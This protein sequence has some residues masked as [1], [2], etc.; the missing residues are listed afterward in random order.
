MGGDVN[1]L[2]QSFPL[3]P[4]GDAEEEG[5][6]DPQSFLAALD[7]PGIDVVVVTAL[8]FIPE[9]PVDRFLQRLRRLFQPSVG[10]LSQ[11]PPMATARRYPW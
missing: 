3:L 4:V 6:T 11:D 1:P 10:P 9:I 8:F 5:E 2:D 7:L